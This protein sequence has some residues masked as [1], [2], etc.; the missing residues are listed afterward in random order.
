MA[1]SQ[2]LFEPEGRPVRRSDETY[3]A[4]QARL[5]AWRRGFTGGDAEV[6][7]T[8]V[9]PAVGMPPVSPRFAPS[10]TGERLGD[11]RVTGTADLPA[12]QV[13]S[14]ASAMPATGT[15]SGTPAPTPSPQPWPSASFG[16]S[17]T[18]GL[19]AAPTM[20]EQLAWARRRTALEA[21][22]FDP[23]W[24]TPPELRGLRWSPMRFLYEP[25]PDETGAPYREPA[26]RGYYRQPHQSPV[27]GPGRWG[28]RWIE[29][30]TNV[31]DPTQPYRVLGTAEASALDVEVNRASLGR[32]LL[33]PEG[34]QIER[35]LDLREPAP[36]WI[37]LPTPAPA[38]T[39]RPRMTDFA[40]IPQR[41]LPVGCPY[42]HAYLPVPRQD[43][44]SGR[45]LSSDYV[46]AIP[47]PPPYDQTP[48]RCGVP[49][50]EQTRKGRGGPDAPPFS[51]QIIRR[52][53]APPPSWGPVEQAASLEVGL[54]PPTGSAAPGQ[55]T[56]EESA[57][58]EDLEEDAI[59]L[60]R[61]ELTAIQQR[62]Q[63][64]KDQ[65]QHAHP[66]EQA[67]LKA[68]LE[69]IRA[70]GI[71]AA[72]RL[73]DAV[74]AAEESGRYG[75]RSS[76]E[77]GIPPPSIVAAPQDVPPQAQPTRRKSPCQELGP[78]G[79]HRIPDG[80]DPADGEPENDNTLIPALKA[81][82]LSSVA[83]TYL[84][85]DPGPE[86]SKKVESV[87]WKLA[88]AS[89]E[90]IPTKANARVRVTW[91]E[92]KMVERKVAAS[93][94]D[95]VWEKAEKQGRVGVWFGAEGG[96]RSNLG[97]IQYV[98]LKLEPTIDG[99]P[100]GT[101]FERPEHWKGYHLDLATNKPSVDGNGWYE[102][103]AAVPG[104][105]FMFDGP[106]LAVFA[107]ESAGAGGLALILEKFQSTYFG[108]VPDEGWM[109]WKEQILKSGRGVASKGVRYTMTFRTYVIDRSET[110]ECSKRVLGSFS[111]RV[112]VEVG[113]DKKPG[114]F[115]AH[116]DG[117]PVWSNQ[118]RSGG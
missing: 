83:G 39:R 117:K 43:Y 108:G 44:V 27:L 106:G 59:V 112:R 53:D 55:P 18:P 110:D 8:L 80:T 114:G 75:E 82:G 88:S 49:V 4:W 76:A 57:T 85:S 102:R 105:A 69:K 73:N 68:E 6:A 107:R 100:V 101:A 2:H 92:G 42:P 77:P 38:I 29:V 67:A 30:E 90:G 62:E 61:R 17:V 89:S 48:W 118:S 79:V 46:P 35:K 10:A 64:L 19:R 109:A 47:L 63:E 20:E 24:G 113:P 41:D 96:G 25:A 81:P 32:R 71:R 60:A 65:L 104:Q 54:P 52:Q 115:D 16:G 86:A 5:D 98:R 72:D 9:T 3:A 97:F 15:T 1:T 23:A 103:Q 45:W 87:K 33:A 93:H 66:A 13:A 7:R 21:T 40:W 70:E 111:W 50:V 31:P 12:P 99:D 91:G 26:D 58:P 56:P 94:G 37:P 51:E 22:G 78:D 14:S 11:F 84:E 116:L 95:R 34:G 74:H 28:W 36:G